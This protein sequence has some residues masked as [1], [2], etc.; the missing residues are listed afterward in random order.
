M[1]INIIDVE[2]TNLKIMTSKVSQIYKKPR[3]FPS[4]SKL[5]KITK[6]FC[7]QSFSYFFNCS[8]KNPYQE[9]YEYWAI[10]NN[11]G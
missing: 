4:L 7:F 1:I 10:L 5:D 9:L 6:A 8:F 3:Y 2:F 11:F